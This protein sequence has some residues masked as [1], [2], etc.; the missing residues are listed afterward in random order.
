[1]LHGLAG[2]LTTA[3]S[4][5][6]LMIAILG[7]ALGSLVGVLPGLGPVSAMAILLPLSARMGSLQGL[8]LLAGVY[9]GSQYGDSVSAILVNV[10]SE[11]PAIVIA[12]DGYPLSQS[13]R[14]G[15]AL[16]VA[17]VGSFVGAMVGLFGVAFL[18]TPASN[19]AIH[20]TA[21]NY[22]IL[23]VLALVVLPAIM[24]VG[25]A[26]GVGAAAL[27][28]S[29]TA[30][31]TDPISGQ[32]RLT[33]AI[34]SLAGGL[35]LV[36]IAVGLFGMAEV[37]GTVIGDRQLWK[38]P[39]GIRLR[40]SLPTRPEWM[41]SLLAM[42][43]GSFLGFVLGLVPGPSLVLGPFASHGVERRLLARRSGGRPH[44]AD[45]RCVSGPKA[46][47]DAAVGGSLIPLLALGVPFTPVTAMLLAGLELHGITPGPTFLAS[48]SH[49]FWGLIGAMVIG[50]LALLVLSVPMVGM[51]V[52][53]LRVPQT[54]RV[55]VL[56]AV[57]VVGVYAVRSNVVDVATLF[58]SGVAGEIFRRRGIQRS[59]VVLG[60][61][62]GPLLETSIGTSLT[63]SQGSL[64]VF[65]GDPVSAIGVGIL[66]VVLVWR[67]ARVM[68][69]WRRR[70]E[71]RSS[72]APGASPIQE[73]TS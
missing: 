28:L 39:R 43:R 71:D 23:I 19:L 48:S 49:L 25:M 47:D 7:A 37:I 58:V 60:F 52:Q 42:L 56:T 57:M 10:P 13:G 40:D 54:L 34:S 14:A 70:S 67:A 32:L 21:P 9:Y 16:T 18:L 53:L 5:S 3:F 27:G 33:G 55:G 2:G 38:V 46:A 29:L 69:G 36:P 66:A 65:V 73:A 59:L 45:L 26:A 68:V 30:I 15:A 6:N 63:S 24:G 22:V 35:E 72:D 44:K 4:L 61:V 50:N 20:L 17:G 12:E 11:P 1:M 8:I 51:W 41:G 62:L 31:G 64:R